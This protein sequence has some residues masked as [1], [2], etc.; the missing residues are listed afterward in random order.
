MTK[1]TKKDT[2]D[3]AGIP[4]FIV[5]MAND[6]IQCV[7][8]LKLYIVISYKIRLVADFARYGG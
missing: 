6:N 4:M 5:E 8:D 2:V 1:V 3:F 7:N